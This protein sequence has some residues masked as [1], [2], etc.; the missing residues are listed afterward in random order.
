MPPNVT[1]ESTDCRI[2]SPTDPLNC[3]NLGTYMIRES[4]SRLH[5]PKQ[6]T[7]AQDVLGRGGGD[8][9]RDSNAIS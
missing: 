3:S 6:L 9:L 5:P 4:I 8:E 2:N 1:K 7:R